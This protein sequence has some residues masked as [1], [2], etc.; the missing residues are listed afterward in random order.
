MVLFD[1]SS[2]LS[3]TFYAFQFSDEDDWVQ[4]HHL[5]RQPE[6]VDAKLPPRKIQPPRQTSYPTA[7]A[8]PLNA[9]NDQY[10]VEQINQPPSYLYPLSRD[11]LEPYPYENDGKRHVSRS[12]SREKSAHPTLHR[13]VSQDE[14]DIK[15]IIIRPRNYDSRFKH[16]LD[17][18]QFIDVVDDAD[19]PQLHK[20]HQAK[21]KVERKSRAPEE[22][23]KS[24][25]NYG[26]YAE[27]EAK[28]TQRYRYGEEEKRKTVLHNDKYTR[29]SREALN[30]DRSSSERERDLFRENLT[31]REK[32]R[33]SQ[34]FHGRKDPFNGQDQS[35]ERRHSPPRKSKYPLDNGMHLVDK[36]HHSYVEPQIAE[37]S[38]FR[39][40]RGGFEN[41]GEHH[42]AKISR[43]FTEKPIKAEYDQPMPRNPYKEPESLPYRE[44]IE[45]MIKSPAMRYKSFETNSSVEGA[46]LANVQPTYPAPEKVRDTSIRYHSLEAEKYMAEQKSKY[47]PEPSS[48][49]RAIEK[50]RSSHNGSPDTVCRVSPKDRFNNAREKFEAMDRERSYVQSD[51]R[52]QQQVRQIEPSHHQRHQSPPRRDRAPNQ[53]RYPPQ[54]SKVDWSSEDE[55]HSP[56]RRTTNGYRDIP[57]GPSEGYGD[58]SRA[59]GPSKSLNNLA[60]GG[61]RHSYAEP[62]R[63]QLPRNSGR[64]G[65][66]AVN[67]Y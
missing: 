9:F 17:E 28:P 64:V 32:Y 51:N 2:Y 59:M 30:V 55:Q 48:R 65:L 19:K 47:G 13:S 63:A 43:S 1:V 11:E 46:K 24:N 31:D 29:S 54:E 37:R 8:P 38:G 5:T 57:T 3:F 7:V 23:P 50:Q 39:P 21:Q 58:H 53:P 10:A 41:G 40:H 35:F 16:I 67:P 26:R 36:L 45:S 33:E 62:M 22:L 56:S 4:D 49:R 25:T 42:D 12:T 14:A 20:P 15:P 61:Y 44:S 66:A 34:K 60:R 6:Q 27:D 18:N 52:Q